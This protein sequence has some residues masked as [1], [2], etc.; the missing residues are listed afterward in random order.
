MTLK[1]MI[2]DTKLRKYDRDYL[3]ECKLLYNV[4]YF[5]MPYYENG[6]NYDVVATCLTLFGY[7]KRHS[8]TACGYLENKHN[9]VVTPY[10]GRFGEGFI[11]HTQYE[12]TN[13]WHK[14]EYWIK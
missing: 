1:N 5:A 13:L 4:D 9:N 6:Y 14:I 10:S 8:A 3:A 2:G 12:K 11:L 7:V